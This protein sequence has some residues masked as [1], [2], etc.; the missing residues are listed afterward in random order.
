[1]R[2]LDFK[3]DGQYLSSFGCMICTFDSDGMATYTLG[4]QLEF[5]TSPINNGKRHLRTGAKYSSCIEVD[6]QICKDPDETY[7]EDRYFTIDEVRSIM[8]W[9]NRSEFCDLQLVDEDMENSIFS[10]SFSNIEKIE[11]GGR[12]IGMNLHFISDKPF[13]QRPPIKSTWNV[14]SSERTFLISDTSDEIGSQYV[15]MVVILDRAGDLIIHNT[16]DNE[17]VII[18]NCV[19]GEK[20]TFSKEQI[21]ETDSDAHKLTIM[22]DF[23]YV[24]PKVMNSYKERRNIFS[25]SI[26]CQVIVEYSPTR[27]VGF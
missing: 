14:T 22:H 21:I 16:Q 5:I 17:D 25:F 15:D 11:L 7:G 10:G 13:A 6:F 24:F 8:R 1:M 3:Y 9:L 27:K 20:I 18:K 2:A 4:S 26:P 23:N 12:I 19:R